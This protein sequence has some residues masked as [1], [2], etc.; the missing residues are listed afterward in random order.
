VTC[1]ILELDGET[2]CNPCPTIQRG[3]GYLPALPEGDLGCLGSG[4]L[5]Q[6]KPSTFRDRLP[7]RPPMSNVWLA[8]DH[9][10][11][12]KLSAVHESYGA[13]LILHL[14]IPT[15]GHSFKL[16]D[17]LAREDRKAGHRLELRSRKQHPE[18]GSGVVIADPLRLFRVRLGG[19]RWRQATSAWRHL[20]SDAEPNRSAM[21]RLSCKSRSSV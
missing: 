2:Q 9:L 5:A 14:A 20:T 15:G 12:G 13:G 8:V 18:I 16:F 19:A 1:A 6:S 21:C 17:K 7:G 10:H 11:A 4:E 3:R